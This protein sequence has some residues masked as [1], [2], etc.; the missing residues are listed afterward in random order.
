[1]WWWNYVIITG[2]LLFGIYV[3]L[4][5]TGYLPM[6]LSHENNPTADSM[7]DNHAES[8]RNQRRHGGEWKDVESPRSRDVAA[9]HPDAGSKTVTA[10]HHPDRPVDRAA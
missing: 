8:L 10:T 7:D 4:M 1:M 6:V 9:I 5:G 2:L 3:F